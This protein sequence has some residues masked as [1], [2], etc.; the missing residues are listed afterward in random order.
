MMSCRPLAALALVA[1]SGRT[2]DSSA[3]PLDVAGRYQVFLTTISGCDNDVTLI[4]PW[5][6][7]PLTVEQEG[8]SLTLD[9]GE[10][11][12]LRGS[13][14][15]AG[16]FSADGAFTWSGA[17]MDLSQDGIFDAA[18]GER[19]LEARFRNRVSVD[20]FESNDCTLEA[21]IEATRISD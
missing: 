1:C 6:Q 16:E 20:G 9:Y 13:V 19:T 11:A 14:D 8:A 18:A 5:A 7:G 10:D 3:P 17:E 4:Q 12:V 2:E 15:G 21:D